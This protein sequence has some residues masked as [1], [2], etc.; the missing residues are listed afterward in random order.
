LE[1][2]SGIKGWEGSNRPAESLKS[3]KKKK[4]RK[5]AKKRIEVNSRD[6]KRKDHKGEKRREGG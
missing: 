1:A 3:Q 4:R 6:V 5:E 2:V